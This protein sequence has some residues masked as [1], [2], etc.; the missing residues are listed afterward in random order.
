MFGSVFDTAERDIV[1]DVAGG[2]YNEEIAESL[3]K[4]DLG[5]GARI[6]AA[7]N[8]REGMLAILEL[9]AATG[10]LVRVRKIAGNEAGIACFEP[11]ECCVGLSGG[12]LISGVY[13]DG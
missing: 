10:A 7:K 8:D 1:D 11:G 5:C 12:G 3:I 4:H 2:T 9:R 13:A 6:G